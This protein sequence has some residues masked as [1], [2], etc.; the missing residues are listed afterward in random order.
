MSLQELQN[1]L[2][3]EEENLEYRF[4]GLVIDLGANPVK[5]FTA[6]R[7]FLHKSQPF[8]SIEALANFS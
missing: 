8:I 6:S 3:G 4:C 2:H 5:V 1:N 7:V